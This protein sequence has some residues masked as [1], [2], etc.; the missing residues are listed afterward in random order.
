VWTTA[1]GTKRS[2]ALACSSTCGSHRRRT[3]ALIASAACVDAVPATGAGWNR[4]ALAWLTAG[5]AH[6]FLALQ[7]LM[8]ARPAHAW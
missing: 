7:H 3:L 8:R 4:R 1:R 2:C 5:A 6:P